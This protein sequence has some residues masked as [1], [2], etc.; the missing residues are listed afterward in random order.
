MEKH[1]KRELSISD[2]IIETVRLVTN[3]HI[4]PLGILHGGTVLKWMV[5]AGSMSAMRV[6]RGPALLVHMDNVFFIN[7]VRLG[8][9][10]VITAW[11]DYIG[12]SSLE[13]TILVEEEDPVTGKRRITTAAHTTY[14]AVDE[15]IRPRPVDACI[16]PK[17][18]IEDELYSRALKRRKE[19]VKAKELKRVIPLD[20]GYVLDNHILANPEDAIAYNAMHAGRLLHVLDET[21]GILA[22]KYVKGIAVTAAVDATD[23]IAPILVGEV[24]DIKAALTYVGRTTVEIGLEV[25]TFNPFTN[26]YR[27]TVTSYFTLVHLSPEGRPSPVPKLEIVDDQQRLIIEEARMRREKRLGLLEFFKREASRIKP[28][29]RYYG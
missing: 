29:R 19:R 17:G 16:N 6:A 27:H 8:K 23:F 12:R 24:L 2:T 25:R 15:N 14:V 13:S 11:I 3:T 18:E 7:P 1:C 5:T 9:N 4:N 20:E 10:A 26:E 22:M 21:A 28:P